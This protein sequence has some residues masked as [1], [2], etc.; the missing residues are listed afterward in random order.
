[1]YLKTVAIVALGLVSGGVLATGSYWYASPY[2]AVNSIREA[3]AQKD[4]SRFNQ[5][6][7][8]PQVREDLKA[9]VITR[10]TEAATE[11]SLDDPDGGLA[12]LGTAL[13]IPIANTLIDS[14]LTAEVVKGL[15]ESSSSGAPKP[16]KTSANP[17]SV[18]DI[19][20]EIA[21]GMEQFE[22]QI[23]QMSGVEMAY[24]GMNQFLVSGR[25]EP[26]VKL[27]FEMTRQGLGNWTIAG[28]I[29]PDV[30]QLQALALEDDAL[31]EEELAIQPSP[32]SLDGDRDEPQDSPFDT[33]ETD[34]IESDGL[35]LA[36]ADDQRRTGQSRGVN[37]TSPDSSTCWFQMRRGGEEFTGFQCTVSSRVNANGNLVYDV[38]E[39]SGVKRA[40][41]LWDD[42]SVEV[43]LRGQ[44]YEGFWEVN[45]ERDVQIQLPQGAMA[46]R[47][48]G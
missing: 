16:Q 45:A 30:Q 24:V 43:F 8:Y 9:Y 4:G 32:E 40:I 34:E 3:I 2:L 7:D 15:I 10:L 47:R 37:A 22:R 23:K 13:V 28:L 38:I 14:Y 12:A 6:V 17:F 33:S 36:N 20:A 19:Q 5:Y 42:S 39:P 46:F 27:G 48:P 44:R 25:L 21:K 11:E 18:P 31:A 29:L 1:M 26:G 35:A 41:V